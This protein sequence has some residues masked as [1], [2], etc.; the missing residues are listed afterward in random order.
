[1]KRDYFNPKNRPVTIR[2]TMKEWNELKKI[3]IERERTVTSL[4]RKHVVEYLIGLDK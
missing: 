2:L 3:A 1:M 4:I